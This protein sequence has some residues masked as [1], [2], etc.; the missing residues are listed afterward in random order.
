MDIR[1]DIVNYARSWMLTPYI[2]GGYNPLIGLDCSQFVIED[3][4]QFALFPDGKD[5]TSGQL[6]DRYAP[7]KTQYPMKGGLAFWQNHVGRIVHVGIIAGDTWTRRSGVWEPDITI[8]E[9]SGPGSAC[10][11]VEAAVKA[12]AHIK[13][14]SL[15]Y[16]RGVILCAFVD[17]LMISRYKLTY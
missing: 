14:R 2:Y 9:A 7:F 6:Y 17:P 13:E 3:Y 15:G 4:K 10:T 16:D 11:T 5:E 8:I 1:N 12:R